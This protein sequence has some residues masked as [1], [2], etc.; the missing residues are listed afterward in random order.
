MVWLGR[1]LSAFN[2]LATDF[3]CLGRMLTLTFGVFSVCINIVRTLPA[4]SG[5][6]RVLA[7]C[8]S[9]LGRWLNAVRLVGLVL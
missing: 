9:G 7:G 8:I 1:N 4:I 6:S 5:A 2:D 3:Y